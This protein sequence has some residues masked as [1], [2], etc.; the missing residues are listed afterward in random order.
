MAPNVK[1]QRMLALAVCLV[2]DR[3][4]AHPDSHWSFRRMTLPYWA[5]SMTWEPWISVFRRHGRRQPVDSR[6]RDMAM[7]KKSMPRADIEGERQRQRGYTHT[8]RDTLKIWKH[9]RAFRVSQTISWRTHNP[10]ITSLITLMKSLCVEPHWYW[11]W[12]PLRNIP[13]SC[14]ASRSGQFSLSYYQRDG[15]WVPVK[16]NCSAAGK[17]TVGLASYW[18][19]FTDSVVYPSTGSMA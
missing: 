6:K 12:W 11:D 7:L 4:Y 15:K 3:L 17:V 14:A 9:Q 16:G 8:H 1:C 19:S 5:L 2:I 13:C 10:G 18:P